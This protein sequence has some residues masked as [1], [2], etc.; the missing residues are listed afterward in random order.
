MYKIYA[1][2]NLF[3]DSTLDDNTI[4]KGTITKEVNKAGSFIFGAYPEHEYYHY[5]QKLKTIITVLKRE[6]IIFRGRVIMDSAGFYNEKTFTCEGELSFMLDSVQRPYNFYGNPR[7]LFVQYLV[8]HNL[9]V[10]DEKRFLIGDITAA[11]D[12]DYIS[13]E[14]SNYPYTLT[15]VNELLKTYGGYLHITRNESG[16]PILNWLHDYP[17]TNTQNIEFGENLL[18][19]LKT[20]DGTEIATVIIPLGAKVGSG[21]NTS[22]L[23]I[24]SVNNDMDYIYDEVAVKKYGWIEKPVIFETSKP[25]ELLNKGKAYLSELIK[26]NTSIQLTALDLSILDRTISS[27]SLGDYIQATSKPHNLNDI[28]LLTKQTIELLHPDRDTVTIGYAFASFTDTSL[29]RNLKTDSIDERIDELYLS[30]N[31][32]IKYEDVVIEESKTI[33][34]GGVLNITGFSMPDTTGYTIVS[35]SVVSMEGDGNESLNIQIRIDKANISVANQS[36]EDITI[37]NLTIRYVMAKN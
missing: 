16:M 19:F 21:K 11:N 34:A 24:K 36:T 32:T 30:I 14:N 10:E 29:N 6:S 12:D 33:S 27:F 28:M 3:Y 20:N 25:E 15:V 18:D 5:I 17:H 37:Q 22:R 13:I 9:Q 26:Q 23:T 31:T 2:G 7:D 35:A 4:T 1:D 8:S